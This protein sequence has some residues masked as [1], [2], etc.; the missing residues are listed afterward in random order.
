[1]SQP[2]APYYHRTDSDTYHWHT[3]CSKNHYPNPGWVK[4]NSKPSGKE[5]CNECKGKQK[6]LPPANVGGYFLKGDTTMKEP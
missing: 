4:T 3:N 1:M 5:Q 2:S 6:L